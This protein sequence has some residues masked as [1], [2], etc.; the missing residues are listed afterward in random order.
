[1]PVSFQITVNPTG[2]PAMNTESVTGNIVACQGTSSAGPNIEQ[3]QVSGS[4]LSGNITITA[5][6]DFEV[7]FDPVTG[8]GKN[9]I[10]TEVGG[11]VTNVPIYVR[12]A[13]SDAAGNISGNIVLSSPGVPDDSVAV[14]GV[15]YALPMVNKVGNQTVNNG[16]ATAAVN[17]TG[18]GSA[19]DW[20]NDMP[21]IGLQASGTG[22]IP[23][24]TPINTTNT[25]VIAKITVVPMPVISDT[26]GCSGVPITFTITIEPSANNIAQTLVIPNTFTPNGDGINDTWV[27]KSLENYPNCTVEIYNR[28][29]E[30]LYS[31]IGYAIPWDGTYKGANLPVGT[32]YYIINLKNG[33]N[34]ISGWVA[35]IK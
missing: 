20:T 10:I 34:A 11:N 6:A 17:F 25:T 5:P 35:I 33:V 19:Y 21:S 13:A 12:S 32:Y 28:W 1:V 26:L 9:V 23:A 3:F 8:Y 15:I 16:A 4:S 2:S 31:S 27:I 18:T 14:T 29:G 22:D 24:F 7:S 30:K